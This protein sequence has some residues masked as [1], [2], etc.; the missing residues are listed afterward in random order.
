MDQPQPSLFVFFRHFN[1][2]MTNF[3]Y[4]LKLNW[5]MRRSC[6]WDSNAYCRMVGE[7]E[8]TDYG[9]PRAA[10]DKLFVIHFVPRFCCGSSTEN[11]FYFEDL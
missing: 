8:S 3:V 5:K 1:N 4:N 11:I 2:T 7:D 6:D 10:P 9:G